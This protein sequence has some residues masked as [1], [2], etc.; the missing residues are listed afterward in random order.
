MSADLV[1]VHLPG[2]AACD[3]SPLVSLAAGARALRSQKICED[4]LLVSNSLRAR[5]MVPN[6]LN[7]SV[8]TC[9]SSAASAGWACPPTQPSGVS[10]A[11]GRA[12]PEV[13]S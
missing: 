6:A 5:A 2:A 3:M 12:E 13:V 10:A 9:T 4:P 11:K 1:A 8:G 7:G